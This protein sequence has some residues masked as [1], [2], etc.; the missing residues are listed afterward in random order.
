MTPTLV[1]RVHEQRPDIPGL[2]IADCEADDVAFGFD[3]PATPGLRSGR[4][5]L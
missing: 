5:A 2:R 4:E 1:I 3:D